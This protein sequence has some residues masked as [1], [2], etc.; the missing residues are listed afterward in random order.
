VAWLHAPVALARRS[1]KPGPHLR[2]RLV[3]WHVLLLYAGVYLTSSHPTATAAVLA[4]MLPFSA[5]SAR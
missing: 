1:T 2:P 5:V 3:A 4:V